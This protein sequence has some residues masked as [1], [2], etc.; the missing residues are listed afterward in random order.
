MGV[1][2]IEE[3]IKISASLLKGGVLPEIVKR[4]LIIDQFTE[5]QA[6]IIINWAY[7]INQ[8]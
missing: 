5:K 6:D 7:K 1:I 2:A 8:K 4:V 3:S